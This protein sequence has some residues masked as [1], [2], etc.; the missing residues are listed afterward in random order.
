MKWMSRQLPVVEESVSTPPGETV[1]PRPGSTPIMHHNWGKLLFMH[2]RVAVNDLRPHIPHAL[3]IETFDGTAWLGIIPFTMWGIRPPALPAI[4]YFSSAHE[5]NVRTYVR[6]QGA[7]GVWFFS[8][9]INHSLGTLAGRWGFS[10]PYYRSSITFH[11]SKDQLSFHL[12]RSGEPRAEFDAHWIIE[13]PVRVTQPG[14]IDAFLLERY[15][16]FSWDGRR[17]WRGPI[18]HMRWAF[19]PAKIV[20]YRSTMLRPLGLSAPEGDPLLHYAESKKVQ[21]Y[22]IEAV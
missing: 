15:Y 10:L 19:Q 2:W 9:D 8:L 6:H 21:I 1:D 22:A 5:L 13:P 4:P 17:L 11:Q 14:T 12:M 18:A 16:L 20:S 3:E 7:S